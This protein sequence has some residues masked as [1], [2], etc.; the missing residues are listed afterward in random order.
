[1]SGKEKNMLKQLQMYP[2]SGIILAIAA[3][4]LMACGGVHVWRM[5]RV[6][7]PRVWEHGVRALTYFASVPAMYFLWLWL[8]RVGV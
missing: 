5:T 3:A 6:S 1:M 4:W 2:L 7:G 8:V